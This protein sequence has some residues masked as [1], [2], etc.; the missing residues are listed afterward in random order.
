[1]YANMDAT[2]DN[3]SEPVEASRRLPALEKLLGKRRAESSRF[4]Q[5]ADRE[6]ISLKDLWQR[7]DSRGTLVAAAL[8]SENPGRTASL[9]ISPILNRT[10]AAE[11]T[12]LIQSM[13]AHAIADGKIDLIQYMA[14]PGDD[15]ELSVLKDAGFID[16]A[17]LVSMERSNSR[18]AK[19]PLALEN[20]VLTSQPITDQAMM[21]L[22]EETYEDSLDCPGLSKLRHAKDIVDG[23]RRGG[24]F[25]PRL[26][27]VLQIN[28]VNAGVSIVNCT[29]AADCMEVAYFGLAKV[30]RHKGLGAHLLDHAL[31]LAAKYAQRSILL[32]VD[33][34]NIPALRLYASRGFR[35]VTR[36]VALALSSLKSST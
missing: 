30:A 34:R 35:V 14:E 31:F 3:R 19:Q 13:V 15:L 16:L 21:E 36:R 1:M 23:H 12:V 8:L 17:L 10:Q 2:M 20:V 18:G 5:A 6:G 32:A 33:E 11:T 28:G 25:D 7:V 27:T 26:W 29:P 24:N 22:L 9:L 4:L